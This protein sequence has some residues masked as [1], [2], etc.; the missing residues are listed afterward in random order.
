MCNKSIMI[1][2]IISI[3]IL[4]NFINLRYLYYD[5]INYAS[6]IISVLNLARK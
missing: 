5:T 1:I 6:N 4:L 3:I 2:I